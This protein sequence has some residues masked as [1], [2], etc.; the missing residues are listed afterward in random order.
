MAAKTEIKI[1]KH[2]L[3]CNLV[4]KNIWGINIRKE[5]IE[6]VDQK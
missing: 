2:A 6:S 3:N 1:R 5:A 4:Q